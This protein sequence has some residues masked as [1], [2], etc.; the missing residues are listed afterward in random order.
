MVNEQSLECVSDESLSKLSSKRSPF[1]VQSSQGHG[2]NVCAGSFAS[3]GPG[4]LLPWVFSRFQA[5]AGARPLE[6]PDSGAAV[7]FLSERVTLLLVLKG[8]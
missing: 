3:Q 1:C 8:T 5:T 4:T 2:A 6:S 7:L